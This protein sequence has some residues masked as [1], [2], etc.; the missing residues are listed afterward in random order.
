MAQAEVI[1]DARN[2]FD[3]DESEFEEECSDFM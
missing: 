2:K 1:R 3:E